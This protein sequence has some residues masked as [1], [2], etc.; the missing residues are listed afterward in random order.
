VRRGVRWLAERR[1]PLRVATPRS[2][3]EPFGDRSDNAGERGD[4]PA[5]RRALAAHPQTPR[6]RPGGRLARP[7]ER[8]N[9][10]DLRYVLAVPLR[11]GWRRDSARLEA[12]EGRSP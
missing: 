12:D 2:L 5:A 6:G 10:D 4:A 3:R 9:F 8:P 1:V 7:D 11:A